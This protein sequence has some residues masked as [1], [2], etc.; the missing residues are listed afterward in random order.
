MLFHLVLSL[1]IYINSGKVNNE[2]VLKY[3]VSNSFNNSLEDY[4]VLKLSNLKNPNFLL[5]YSL[6]IEVN[7][8]IITSSTDEEHNS[9]AFFKD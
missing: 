2:K 7:D 8:D 5:K 4:N 1:I 3:L 9:F 6:G